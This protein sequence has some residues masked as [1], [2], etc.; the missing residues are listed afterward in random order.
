MAQVVV[1][2]E[3]CRPTS[4]IATGGVR[5]KIDRLGV[6]AEHR[7]QLVVHDLDH[8]LAGRD[9]LDAR[10]APTA[11]ALHRVGERAHHVERHVGFE[12]RAPH[13]AHGLG[14]VALGQ[15]TAPG[16]LVEDAG[17]AIGQGLEHGL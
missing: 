7:D 8:H 10:S 11:F 13:L 17:Q 16:E 5:R 6:R 2:P 15:R 9:R 12:Q 4:M 3:P 14:D 1:L